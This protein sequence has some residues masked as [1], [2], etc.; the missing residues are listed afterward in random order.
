MRHLASSLLICSMLA[1]AASAA[2]PCRQVEGLA[3]LLEPKTV[4]LLGELHGTAEAPAFAGNVLC[5][6]GAR[7]LKTTLALEVFHE[8]QER[9]NAYLASDGGEAARAALL[10]GPF[11][12]RPFQ[13]GR[14]SRAMLELVETARRLRAA[15]KS[16]EIVL[17]DAAV[18]TR[19][20]NLEMANRL[21]PA[22]EA[23][24]EG[25][26]VILTGNLHSPVRKDR[27]GYVAMGFYIQ[28]QHPLRRV[29]A[30]DLIYTGGT[31]WICQSA[32][33]CGE[34]TL[35]GAAGAAA[36]WK[37]D[38]GDEPTQ[39]GHHGRYHL[40]AISASPPAVAPAAGPA[41]P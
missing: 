6:A 33:A 29:V 25:L 17:F 28:D 31:A 2:E 22:I 11:W 32:T 5:L 4:L 39:R 19:S 8:E 26:V 36:E 38:F 24:A 20:R 7:G 15:G 35:G 9:F 34:A 13:D 40:G 16:V 23:A 37:V 30:L 27:E 18:P 21:R 10:G 41:Q 12:T 1:S 3:P 14:A